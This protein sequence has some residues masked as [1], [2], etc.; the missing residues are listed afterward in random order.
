MKNRI[1]SYLSAFLFS[2]SL[3][4]VSNIALAAPH[5]R[6]HHDRF[7]VELRLGPSYPNYYNQGYYS[8]GYVQCRWIRGHWDNYGY[9]VP[10]HR[11]CWR[12]GY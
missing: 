6:H 11:A 1:Y 4:A 2:I 10:G 7:N 9:W 3:L 8:G 12:Y 5:H